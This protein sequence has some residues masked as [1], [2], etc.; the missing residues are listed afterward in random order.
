MLNLICEF[1]TMIHLLYSPSHM[2]KTTTGKQNVIM[3]CISYKKCTKTT[4]TPRIGK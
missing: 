2:V 1:R 4:F 3:P